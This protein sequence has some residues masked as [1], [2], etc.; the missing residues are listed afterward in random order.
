LAL[1]ARAQIRARAR[2]RPGRICE[3]AGVRPGRIWRCTPVPTSVRER[4]LGRERRERARASKRE[5]GHG[6]ARMWSP[7]SA[8]HTHTTTH[9][10]PRHSE[11]LLSS[12]HVGA[13]LALTKEIRQKA[14]ERV[15]VSTQALEHL[16]RSPG[17]RVQIHPRLAGHRRR[18]CACSHSRGLS[19]LSVTHHHSTQPTSLQPG[20]AHRSPCETTSQRQ[21]SSRARR[22]TLLS[23]SSFAHTHT[24]AGADADT[25]CRLALHTNTFPRNRKARETRK[26][27]QPAARRADTGELWAAR[28]QGGEESVV[29]S[30]GRY[31][32]GAA[33][34]CGLVPRPC[35][36]C[37]H[38][39]HN[40][41]PG[42]R[43]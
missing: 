1:H 35:R 30:P 10:Q 33:R 2:V 7:I 12:S 6:K 34:R 29:G 36:L 8:T 41:A 3:F 31:S 39:M 11:T 21:R 13:P 25:L 22:R 38:D 28:L 17:R 40:V 32:R 20:R 42:A 19:V 14:K 43:P 15:G 18:A 5:P 23:S 27:L 26:T 16:N 37:V 4:E 9:L 24:G